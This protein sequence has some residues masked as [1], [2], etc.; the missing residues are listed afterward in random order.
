MKR[1]EVA[2][3]LGLLSI[4]LAALLPPLLPLVGV[5]G[6]RL[7]ALQDAEGSCANQSGNIYVD[8]G[9]GTVTDNRSGLVWLKRADCLT[10]SNGG[11]VYPWDKAMLMVAAL[12]DLSPPFE[13]CGLSDGSTPGEWR[14]PTASE[15]TEMVE[16]AVELGCTGTYGP[17]ITNDEGTACWQEGSGTASF[18]GVTSSFYWSATTGY[19]AMSLTS[20]VFDTAYLYSRFVWPV[21]GGQ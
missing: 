6:P 17:T 20:G 16:D 9:N 3:W 5:A 13:D 14:L 4:G 7:V 11:A 18:E 21:R 1:I 10:N 2:L 19:G 8:C 15:W 12:A